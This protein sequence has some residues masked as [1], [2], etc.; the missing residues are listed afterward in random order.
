MEATES[1]KISGSAEGVNEE[2]EGIPMSK[3][4]VP[5]QTFDLLGQE[6]SILLILEA[7]KYPTVDVVSVFVNGETYKHLHFQREE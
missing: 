6:I 5:I 7:S 3:F 4:D 1:R 2:K